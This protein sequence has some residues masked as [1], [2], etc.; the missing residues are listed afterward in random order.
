M[1]KRVVVSVWNLAVLLY[2]ERGS[3]ETNSSER[4][5]GVPSCECRRRL[6]EYVFVHP[7]SYVEMA[8]VVRWSWSTNGRGSC[9]RHQLQ[10]SES[11]SVTS[12]FFGLHMKRLS[13]LI[14]LSIWIRLNF[15]HDWSQEAYTIITGGRH[16]NKVEV[17]VKHTHVKGKFKKVG[18]VRWT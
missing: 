8:L 13:Y 15:R 6:N 14:Y 3:A 5:L 7:L 17:N 12:F 18:P 2:S 9:L 10:R 11:R 4:H 1:C 16:Y